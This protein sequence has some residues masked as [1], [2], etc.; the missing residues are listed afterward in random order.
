MIII[1]ATRKRIKDR[2]IKWEESYHERSKSAKKHF[3]AI[4]PGSYFR[5][6]GYDTTTGHPYY[7]V[8]G[9]AISERYGKMFFAGVKK[10]PKDPRKKS[11]SPTGKYFSAL[12]SALSHAS[13]MWGIKFPKNA[14]AF[15]KDDLVPIKI[16]RHMKGMVRPQ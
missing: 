11:Y 4:L 2:G 7:V 14:G 16:P 3:D 6:E 1:E 15:T 10:M 13:E 8:V 5:W 9:P 12:R